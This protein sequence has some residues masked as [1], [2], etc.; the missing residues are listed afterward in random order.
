MRATVADVVEAGGSDIGQGLFDEASV[1]ATAAG[2]VPR[3][4]FVQRMRGM[5]AQPGL[6]LTA[7]MMR[8]IECGNRI[9]AEHIVGDLIERGTP[10]GTRLLRI[11]HVHLKS[12]EARRL[13][14]AR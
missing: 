9:E 8:D 4:N 6:V 2:Y 14:E 7:S 11:A 3:A 10:D 1:I 5:L 13:R 12:Y